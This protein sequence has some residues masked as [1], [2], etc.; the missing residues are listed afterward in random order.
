MAVGAAVVA[1]AAP[2]AAQAANGDPVELG[3]ENSATSSTTVSIGDV[4]G[5]V[6]PTLALENAD[7]PTLYL[8]P[9][10]AD[11]AVALEIG[12]LA[13]TELGPVLGVNSEFGPTTTFLV[14]GIDLAAVP[15]SY[16]LPTP[17]RL[18]DTRTAAG[19][20]RVIRTSA[21]AYD[22]SFRL[23]AG[24]WLDVEVAVEEADSRIPGAYLNVTATGGLAGG[25]LTAYP[26]PDFPNTS[27]VNFAKGAT[28]ANSTFVATGIVLGRF[29]VRIRA[30]ATT[31]VVLDLTGISIEGTIATPGAKGATSARRSPSSAAASAARTRLRSTLAARVLGRVAR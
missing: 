24:A 7:G 22:P 1:A 23:K 20:R 17:Q 8:Q 15:T 10:D 3:A 9:Q 30:S 31:H 25:Y 18:L 5:S 4:S 26:P 27:T 28:I 11:Y 21:G 6:D 14:T 29:A 16:P 12:Q 2:G 13:N 19:R